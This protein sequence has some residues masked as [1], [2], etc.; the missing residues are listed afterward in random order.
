MRSLV[1]NV[2]SFVCVY[3]VVT[4]KRVSNV[5]IFG[6]VHDDVVTD[7]CVSYQSRD[8]VVNLR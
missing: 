8:N 7:R 4:L 6:R 5:V 2:A 3:D 1:L